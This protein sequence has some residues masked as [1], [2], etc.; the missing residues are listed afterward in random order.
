MPQPIRIFEDLESSLFSSMCKMWRDFLKM[1]ERIEIT[2]W[3]QNFQKHQNGESDEVKN[4]LNKQNLWMRVLLCDWLKL[5]SLKICKVY[6]VTPSQSFFDQ[7]HFL[8]NTTIRI[9]SKF[10]GKGGAISWLLFHL[11]WKNYVLHR[12]FSSKSW[13]V[14][15]FHSWKHSTKQ[16]FEPK[17][18]FRK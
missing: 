17:F 7:Y 6:F 2:V 15:A 3:I 16:H 12:D 4:D 18:Q 10:Y 14:D 13:I 11:I 1:S 5:V 9:F 8:N